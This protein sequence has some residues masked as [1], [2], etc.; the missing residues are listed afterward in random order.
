L[1]HRLL[2]SSQSVDEPRLD[3]TAT[4]P[5]LVDEDGVLVGLLIEASNEIVGA[6]GSSVGDMHI[7]NSTSREFG[8][9][10]SISFHEVPVPRLDVS[11]D[12]LYSYFPCPFHAWLGVDHEGDG[13]SNLS[14]KELG[15]VCIRVDRIAVNGNKELAV[16]DV[17]AW[18]TK[19][20]LILLFVIKS[21]EDL[22]KAHAG[23]ED[24]KVCAEVPDRDARGALSE[25]ALTLD[26]SVSRSEFTNEEAKNVVEVASMI[27]ILEVALILFADRKPILATHGGVVEVVA[28][29]APDVP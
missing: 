25:V 6:F 22:R 16:F 7:A 4:I 19:R 27:H 13:L 29:E 9:P 20:G 5:S 10:L 21:T 14:D 8:D 12:G 2:L 3:I 15:R 23:T 11:S 28:L 17:N 24:F 26:V 18:E 1:D